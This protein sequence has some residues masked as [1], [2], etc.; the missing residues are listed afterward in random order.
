MTATIDRPPVRSDEPAS[1]PGR[2][3]RGNPTLR[4][5]LAALAI[6]LIGVGAALVYV[7]IGDEESSDA[8]PAGVE[9]LVEEYVAAME[10][11]DYERLR[12]LVSPGFRR[13]FY[14]GDKDGSPWRDVWRIEAYE[15]WE[16]PKAPLVDWEI[17][18]VGDPTVLGDGPWF[19]S[20]VQLWKHAA[21]GIEYE[22]ISTVVV[23]EDGAGGLW[24]D[25]VHWAGQA[26]VIDG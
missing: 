10:A 13:A 4:T 26:R 1:E 25:E 16:E 15:F 17:E 18:R 5:A 9:E 20:E 8:P 21:V 2:S 22:A 7:A 23:V 12:S 14:Q 6:F 19:V 3:A 24:V 11:S